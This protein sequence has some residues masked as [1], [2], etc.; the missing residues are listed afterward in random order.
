MLFKGKKKKIGI[1]ILSKII[2][3]NEG[4]QKTLKER[5]VTLGL[6]ESHPYNL[7]EHI[8][9][10]EAQAD[11]CGLKEH[12]F[13]E[14]LKGPI[15]VKEAGCEIPY[16]YKVTV[17]NLNIILF[18]DIANKIFMHDLYNNDKPYGRLY[19]EFKNNVIL[20]PHSGVG[21]Y[22]DVYLGQSATL[23]F[24]GNH[25]KNVDIVVRV[26]KTEASAP[27]VRTK[28][29]VLEF[30]NNVSRSL[31]SIGKDSSEE[32]FPVVDSW[33]LKRGIRGKIYAANKI[34]EIINKPNFAENSKIKVTPEQAEEADDKCIIR[35]SDNEFNALHV[36]GMTNFYF[37]GR[38]VIKQL[39]PYVEHDPEVVP[40]KISIEASI[41]WGAG[42][43]LD[44]DGKYFFTH[45]KIFT[46]LKQRAIA[47]NDTAQEMILQREIARC[48]HAIAKSEKWRAWQDRTIFWFSKWISNYGTSWI[49]PLGWLIVFNILIAVSA[50][51][52]TGH[53][54]KVL[55]ILDALPK[56]WESL[57]FTILTVLSNSSTLVIFFEL[58]NPTS[59][60]PELLDP[61]SYLPKMLEPKNLNPAPNAWISFLFIFQKVILAFTLYEMIKI[62]RR[63][64][65]K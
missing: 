5:L 48:D 28:V 65:K 19:F 29:A 34:E 44:E 63:F 17:S 45:K 8:Q 50:Q 53:N 12:V 46:T 33:R 20:N 24:I 27:I 51:C 25:F 30:K 58:F 21:R 3:H 16:K 10:I 59:Y 13:A 64:G 61:T 39:I 52:I 57:D 49:W 7:N 15:F 35:I 2:S 36:F 18:K 42:Q 41:H 1:E 40:G 55:V 60:L 11:A 23:S 22:I 9:H 4:D 26:D 37:E 62:F 32:I 54:F 31:I 14:K 6:S 43:N 47:N 56:V 38:N